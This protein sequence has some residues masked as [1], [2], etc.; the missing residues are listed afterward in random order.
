MK[1]RFDRKFWAATATAAGTA[2]AAGLA[3][4][5]IRNCHHR[6][7]SSAGEE[8]LEKAAS[9][10][11]TYHG[12]TAETTDMPAEGISRNGEAGSIASEK[13]DRA[14]S[15]IWNYYP[16]PQMRRDSFYS[17]NGSWKLNGQKILVPFP[18]QSL[19]SGYRGSVGTHLTYSREFI[20]PGG[21]A[22]PRE[23]SLPREASFPGEV[24]YSGEMDPLKWKGGRILLHFGAVDQ[25]AEVFLNGNLLGRHEGGYLPFS[26]DVTEYVKEGTNRIDEKAID[27]LSVHYPY[28]KQ[29]KARGGMWYTPVSG[30]WQS[31]WMEC[32]PQVYIAGL[33]V[34]ADTQKVRVSVKSSNEGCC[35]AEKSFANS[36][37]S[38]S[39]RD[40]ESTATH[41]MESTTTRKIEGIVTSDTESIAANNAEN[42]AACNTEGTAKDGITVTITLHDG[43]R[44]TVQSAGT[45]AEIDLTEI[46]LADGKAYQPV[47]WNTEHPYLYQMSVTM[48][49]DTVTSYFGLRTIEVKKVDGIP[50]V[51]LNGEPIFLHGV[52][53]QGYFCDGIYLPAKEEEYEQDVLRMKALGMNLLRKH[54]KI[55]PECFYYYCDA[56]GVLVMQDMVNNG[57]YSWIRDTA[58][59]TLGFCRKKDGRSWHGRKRRDFF[60]R[61]MADTIEHLY[62]HPCI[63]AYTIF[64]EGW[65][66]F[67]SD[68]MYR[69]AKKIDNTRLYD[70]TS[71]WFSQMES[72]FDS[73]HIYFRKLEIPEKP[74]KPLLVSE[75]GGYSL[76]VPGHF[77]TKYAR[78]GYGACKGRTELTMR[79]KK[80]YDE[81]ILPAIPGGLCGC[82]YTQL[83]DVE[84][85]VNGFYTY[86]R[87]VCKVEPEVM[88]EIAERL[89]EASSS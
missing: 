66:Q 36:T 82:I 32:V 55:E 25:V 34:T 5:M 33:K 68:D 11:K 29:R 75:C 60:A 46:K 10:G 27:T 24:A 63:I 35:N 50:R 62:N 69:Q 59:P 81:T 71:G 15:E 44:Y 19:L 65:G 13:S 45:K 54:I 83:S 30:I 21:F 47:L 76:R 74:E 73:Q 89:E 72:D 80:L 57:F 20:L 18:P 8:L 48:G 31:V 9:R 51:C 37:R 39:A 78:Y 28:G 38:V 41:N 88:K 87:K 16:R 64:N 67:E 43:T 14:V 53:D 22:C 77:Y 1:K 42:V 84:D 7:V 86:D 4:R 49:E 12:R 70:A 85:E 52:L 79:I 61:H 26:Y 3:V 40:T 23:A 58:L 6:L 2:A 17:L 56:H